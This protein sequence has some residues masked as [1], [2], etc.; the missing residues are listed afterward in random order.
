MN[1]DAKLQ[2]VE[3]RLLQYQARLREN[4]GTVASPII[5][6]I[7]F[8]PYFFVDFT[9]KYDQPCRL[10]RVKFYKCNLWNNVL[11]GFDLRHAT[12]EH[13]NLSSIYLR[14]TDAAYTLFHECNLRYSA[15][16]RVKL[17]NAVLERCDL[18]SAVAIG[19]SMK[20]IKLKGC[21]I[22]GMDLSGVQGLPSTTDLLEQYFEFG[23]EGVIVY[24]AFGDTTYQLRRLDEKF[25][26]KPEAGK[27]LYET[28]DYTRNTNCGCGV[29]FATLEW[30]KKQYYNSIKSGETIVWKCLIPYRYL[31]DVVMP[32]NTD[33]KGRCAYLILLEPVPTEQLR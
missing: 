7:S 24:K 10:T 15:L 2:D 9:K 4:E 18:H 29:N 14:E 21:N 3:K 5:S 13:C 32:Y 27:M 1:N 6:N 22:A 20:G 11:N 30:L 25:D 16:T 19:A 23:K 28:V 8:P 17:D 26:W 12:F 31:A 33:G